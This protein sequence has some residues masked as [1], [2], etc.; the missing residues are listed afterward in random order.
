MKAVKNLTLLVL[1]YLFCS[2]GKNR[3][4]TLIYNLNTIDSEIVIKNWEFT[5]PV[6]L[7]S[8]LAN[9][10]DSS[11]NKTSQP[12]Q[13]DQ[14]SSYDDFTQMYSEVKSDS[15]LKN[16]DYLTRYPYYMKGSLIRIDSVFKMNNKYR[17]CYAATI[18]KSDEERD[19]ALIGSAT[20]AIQIWVNGQVVLKNLS[21]AY[22][23][24]YQYPIEAHFLKGE[25]LV[26]VK[27]TQHDEDWTFL[28]KACSINY[29]NKNSL[30]LN[31]A[32]F[33]ENYLLPQKQALKLKFWSPFIAHNIPVK[34]FIS[35]VTNHNLFSK[36]CSIG[37]EKY[38][39]L[40]NLPD[41]PY[42]IKL[43]SDSA[44]IHQDFFLGDYKKYIKRLQ[45]S[46]SPSFINDKFKRNVKILFDRFNY[47]D[48]VSVI[49]DNAFE[50]KMANLLFEL[51]DINQ[52]YK[53]RNEVFKNVKG[54]HIRV[55]EAIDN[56]ADSYM[57]Y[58]PPTYKKEH[59]LPLVIMMPHA[60]GLRNFS[61][62]TYVSDINRIEHICKLAD[63]F[64]YAVLWSS[65]R[66]YDHN[67]LTNM[68]PQTIFNT[69]TDIRKDYNI[70]ST[71]LYAYGDCAGGA[72]TLFVANKYPSLFAAVAVEGPAIPKPNNI[73]DADYDYATEED[74]V[75]DFYNTIENYKNTP[76]LIAHS[77]DD[78]KA[79]IN[80]SIRLV[81]AIQHAGGTARLKKIYVKKGSDQFYFF[82]NLMPENKTL[83][84]FFSFY[85]GYSKKVSDTVLF[86]TRQ[87]KYNQSSWVKVR[88]IVS[89]KKAMISA[90]LNRQKNEI[91]VTTSNVI[92]FSI[93]R[94]M[95]KVN[96]QNI[97]VKVNGKLTKTVGQDSINLIINVTPPYNALGLIKNEFVEGPA[98]DFFSRPFLVVRGTGGSK[99][100][101]IKYV[102][103]IDT[104]KANWIKNFIGDTCRIKNDINITADDQKNYNLLLIGTAETNLIIKQIKDKLPIQIKANFI[105]ISNN[106]FEGNDLSLICV[107]PNPLN[108]KKYVLLASNNCKNL[109][110][111][112]LKDIPYYGWYDF[113]IVSQSHTVGSGNFNKYWR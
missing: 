65:F 6:Y 53:T 87:L 90:I 96:N 99:L 27:L 64:G 67:S 36:A 48:T 57:I 68:A 24:G 92:S 104:F 84:D 39:S 46:L 82:A 95:L 50:R 15:N 43:V 77:I 5:K 10:L 9:A 42:K 71:R 81:D 23:N 56:R 72:I 78:Q 29:A 86:T 3:P 103:A 30:G 22:I 83:T 19:V 70:D 88:D 94:S 54:L 100:E 75:N 110:Y 59:P 45:R 21:H 55:P 44:T 89:H 66:F 14:L 101:R 12:D 76:V 4:V 80:R 98:N 1:L 26:L 40:V 18:M 61:I 49:H 111:T 35:D 85:N 17:S 109:A 105:S 58:V 11:F 91:E 107:Y 79:D 106:K 13:G 25:N 7:D 108:P 33:C 41:G 93:N 2:C 38:I 62:S 60:T 32:S 20:G 52:R 28:L 69:L 97:A 47:L 51:G 34:I 16:S 112:L 8:Y 113:L 37:K 73:D 102:A 31:Y 63:K 74:A